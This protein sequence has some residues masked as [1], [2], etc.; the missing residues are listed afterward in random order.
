M[1]IIQLN[2]AEGRTVEQKADAMAAITEAVVRTLG[3]RPEQVRIMINEVSPVHYAIAGETV[4]A[5][6]AK[7]AAAGK[8]KP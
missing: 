5:R 7:T 8:D 6:N 3:A 2:I 4:A 1:P